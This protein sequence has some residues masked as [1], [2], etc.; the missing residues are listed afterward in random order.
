MFTAFLKFKLN[1]NAYHAGLISAR[2][3]SPKD[4]AVFLLISAAGIRQR[5]STGAANR[6]T[7]VD[8]LSGRL[9]RVDLLSGR[10]SSRDSIRYP[11][12]RVDPLSRRLSIWKTLDLLDLLSGILSIK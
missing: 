12:Y 4:H 10:P 11:L 6:L 1:F 2:T 8:S 3:S 9:R 5:R 7:L